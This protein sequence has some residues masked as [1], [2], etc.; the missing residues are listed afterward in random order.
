MIISHYNKGTSVTYIPVKIAVVITPQ[1]L[2]LIAYSNI[3]L[4]FVTLLTSF[5][6]TLAVVGT[7]ET[8]AIPTT[9]LKF[10]PFMR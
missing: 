3:K 7:Q 2:A 1:I 6:A 5:C 4:Y 9:G 8:P 10:L